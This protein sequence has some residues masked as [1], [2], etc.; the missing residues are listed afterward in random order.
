MTKTLLSINQVAVR[1]GKTAYTIKRWYNWYEKLTLEELEEYKKDGMPELPNYTALGPTKWRYWAE[2]DIPK[3]KK[4]S[5][6]VPH[7]KSGVMAN[8]KDK[9]VE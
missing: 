7:T 6:W 1:V 3:L 8:K 2:E 5:K 4:F 9:E